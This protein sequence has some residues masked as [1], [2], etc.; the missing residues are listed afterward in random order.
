MKYKRIEK[1][2]DRIIELLET[3]ASRLPQQ[4]AIEKPAAEAPAP[5]ASMPSPASPE[6]SP[7]VER[8]PLS[9]LEDREEWRKL[10]EGWEEPA[11]FPKAPK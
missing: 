1:K 9:L 2:V 10:I 7:K 11:G 3:I 4:A 8:D 5:L 6:A